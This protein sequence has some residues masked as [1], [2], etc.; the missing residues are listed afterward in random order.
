M[1]VVKCEKCGSVDVEADTR[2]AP[3]P[4][5]LAVRCVDCGNSW[6]RTPRVVCPRCGSGD[7]DESGY[8][9]WAFDDDEEARDAPGT[10]DWSHVDRAVFRCRACRKEWT[11]VDAV[12]P[13]RPEPS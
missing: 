6:V 3:P 2:A 11:T 4:G 10:A 5:R 7:V 8:E 13:Y 12:R 9:G 1:A